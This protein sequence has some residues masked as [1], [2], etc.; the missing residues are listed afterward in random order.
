MRAGRRRAKWAWKVCPSIGW[1]GPRALVSSGGL[2]GAW[3]VGLRSVCVCVLG[4]GTSIL[5]MLAVSGFFSP[6]ERCPCPHLLSSVVHL[7]LR[8]LF[9]PQGKQEGCGGAVF[10]GGKRATLL[11]LG[12][13]DGLVDT[14]D[15]VFSDSHKPVAGAFLGL[16]GPAPSRR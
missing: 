1:P 13:V 8:Y 3:R 10:L 6:W 2:A 14:A 16:S 7:L 9:A 5:N 15:Q 4:A 11:V 12:R